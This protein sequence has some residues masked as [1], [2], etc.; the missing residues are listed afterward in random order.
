VAT[1]QEADETIRTVPMWPP[2]A[3]NKRLLVFPQWVKAAAPTNQARSIPAIHHRSGFLKW[4]WNY[5]SR[6]CQCDHRYEKQESIVPLWPLGRYKQQAARGQCHRGHPQKQ[7]T[8]KSLNQKRSGYWSTGAGKWIDRVNVTIDH[9]L[10]PLANSV[11][12][13][14]GN[15]EGDSANKAIRNNKQQQQ[16]TASW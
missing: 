12:V 1:T 8:E 15:H 7:H 16:P 10:Q 3:T 9:R 11:S 4:N 5:K 13:T 14:I 6:Q 2:V